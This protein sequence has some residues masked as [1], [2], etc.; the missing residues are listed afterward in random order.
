MAPR[1]ADVTFA[2]ATVNSFWEF[3]ALS[4]IMQVCNFSSERSLLNKKL[5]KITKETIQQHFVLHTSTNLP[6][7]GLW[8]PL[9]ILHLPG[10]K[11]R[12]TIG[13]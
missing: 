6:C 2:T 12:I 3:A 7:T 10:S 4:Q 5:Q 1:M 13:H 11:Q 9:N 8:F